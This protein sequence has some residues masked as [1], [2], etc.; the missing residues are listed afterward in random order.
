VVGV[1]EIVPEVERAKPA[2]RV[3][4]EATL[5]VYGEVPPV[6]ARVVLE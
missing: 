6:A 3:L 1:P 5:Q 4:P 2:G